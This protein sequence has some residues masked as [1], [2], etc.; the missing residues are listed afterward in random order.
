MP[1]RSSRSPL[2]AE[3][4]RFE[5]ELRRLAYEIVETVFA[6]ELARERSPRPGAGPRPGRARAARAA[7]SEVAKTA[8]PPAVGASRPEPAAARPLA[9]AVPETPGKR[10]RWTRELVIEELA[11]WLLS[12]VA[13]DAAFLTRRGQPGLVAAAK[14]LF[15]R[16]DAALNAAN[17]HLAQQYPEGPPTK[18]TTASM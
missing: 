16:F 18:R 12:G 7:R 4:S 17:L 11:T 9:V 5:D 15:G 14:R 3:V 10:R 6:E 1:R 13:I 8:P 2:A